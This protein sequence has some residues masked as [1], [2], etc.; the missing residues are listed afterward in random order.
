VRIAQTPSGRVSSAA[1]ATFAEP[2]IEKAPRVRNERRVS[3][4]AGWSLSLG[5]AARMRG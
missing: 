1:S 4:V 5:I 2:V 3:A